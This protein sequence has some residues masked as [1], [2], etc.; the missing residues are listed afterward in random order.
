LISD[1]FAQVFLDAAGDGAWTWYGSDELHQDVPEIAARMNNLR[2]YTASRTKF[3]DDF[4]TAA[5][6]AGIRQVVILAAGLDARAWRLP[7]RDGVV[8]YEIDQPQVLQFKG[9]TLDEHGLAPTARY[10]AV[11][12]DLRQDWPKALRD[13]GFDPTAPSAWSAEG[14]LPYL[15]ADAQ[16]LLFDRIIDSSAPGSRIAVE[17]FGEHFFDPDNLERQRQS[18]QRYMAAAA[19]AGHTLP[20]PSQLWYLEPR[21]EVADWLRAHGWH[22]DAVTARELMARFHREP[23]AD[24]EPATPQTMFVAARL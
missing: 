21:T 15:P 14:L 8:V 9:E 11:A 18:R 2:A 23:P 1:P 17:A 10:V 16:D 13:S 24:A 12:A 20:D 22:V 6:D 3:F 4:F 7:W 19:D 5:A